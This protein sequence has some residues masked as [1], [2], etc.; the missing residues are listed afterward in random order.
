[1][2]YRIIF[3]LVFLLALSSG[4]AAGGA[5]PLY[6]EDNLEVIVGLESQEEFLL[7]SPYENTTSDVIMSV[8]GNAS[9]YVTLNTKETTISPGENKRISFTINSYHKSTG[10]VLDP[11]DEVNGKINVTFDRRGESPSGGSGAGINSYAELPLNITATRPPSGGS[12]YL[13]AL[14]LYGPVGWPEILIS[15]LLLIVVGASIYLAI[16]K[17]DRDIDIPY[18]FDDEDEFT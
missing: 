5:D 4:I 13:F 18:L 10:D 8:E 17:S 2:K 7:S 11:G 16:E 15:L 14:P 9:N 1:M 6:N 12:T 3:G